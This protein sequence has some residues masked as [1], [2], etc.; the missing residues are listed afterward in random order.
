VPGLHLD[1]IQIGFVTLVENEHLPALV[2]LRDAL[3]AA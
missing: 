1:R 3:T 2:A